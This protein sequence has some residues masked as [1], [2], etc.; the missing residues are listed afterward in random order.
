[1]DVLFAVQSHL[2]P[3]SNPEA[4]S[5]S[6]PDPEPRAPAKRLHT[7]TIT[8][9]NFD[10]AV[11]NNKV[12]VNGRYAQ[13]SSVN[14]TTLTAVVPIVSSGKVSVVTPEGVGASSSYLTI[15]P[16]PYAPSNIGSVVASSI[17]N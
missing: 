17:G 6:Y 4:S 3:P 7:I 13:V 2:K 1:M 15:T 9:T 16:V 11:G 5:H 14:S 12:L 10:P 8:G